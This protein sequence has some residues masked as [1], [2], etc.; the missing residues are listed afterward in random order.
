MS[1]VL[2]LLLVEICREYEH[3]II[4]VVLPVLI[5]YELAAINQGK[6]QRLNR[7][8]DQGRG[9][10]GRSSHRYV[11]KQIDY[12]N[13]TM[14]VTF[15]RYP[16]DKSLYQ[17]YDSEVIVYGVCSTPSTASVTFGM[18][19]KGPFYVALV[20]C[21]IF[22]CVWEKQ[23]K[24]WKVRIQSCVHPATRVSKLVSKLGKGIWCGYR[25]ISRYKK[26]CKTCKV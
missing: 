8:Y 21:I 23:P 4:V 7:L 1:I 12:F 15:A 24:K 3:A 18:P 11:K 9:L 22:H 17:N 10:G 5:L 26:Y 25:C 19:F 16:Y 14:A 13:L 20:V 6:D 2:P